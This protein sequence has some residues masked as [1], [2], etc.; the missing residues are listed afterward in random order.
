M[1]IQTAQIVA[2]VLSQLGLSAVF[3]WL[4]VRKDKTLDEKN[5]QVLEAFKENTKVQAEL[6]GA[7]RANTEVTNKNVTVTDKIYD[8]LISKN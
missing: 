2:P 4:F 5:Q 8:A 7:I 3:L 1:D 6:M